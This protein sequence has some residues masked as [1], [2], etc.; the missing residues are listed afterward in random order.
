MPE[1]IEAEIKNEQDGQDIIIKI[2][3]E[4]KY[5]IEVKSRW[6]VNS[7]Y[8]MSK[9][10]TLKA[11]AQQHNYAL[12]TVDMTQYRGDDRLKV[13]SFDLIEHLVRF[14]QNIGEKVEHL[15]DVLEQTNEPDTIHLD[16][17]YRTLIPMSFVEKGVD[18]KT[19]ENHLVGVLGSS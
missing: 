3:G 7:S 2:G 18:M 16:G 15:I 4:S 1:T 12:C 14:N 8:R 6:D 10:Q 11:Y 19:F 9:N 17:D 13:K 5:F